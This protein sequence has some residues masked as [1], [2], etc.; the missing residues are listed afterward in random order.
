VELVAEQVDALF[1]PAGIRWD[2]R[3][4]HLVV[5]AGERFDTEA[6]YEL[7]TGELPPRVIGVGSAAALPVLRGEQLLLSQTPVEWDAWVRLWDPAAGA[8]EAPRP[9]GFPVVIAPAVEDSA[10]PRSTE[11]STLPRPVPAGHA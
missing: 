5:W 11:N 9:P 7:R 2:V 4:G 1:A 8:S 10:S 3:E 6:V